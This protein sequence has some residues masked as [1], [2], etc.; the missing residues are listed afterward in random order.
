VVQ[1]WLLRGRHAPL[2]THDVLD[3]T[4]TLLGSRIRPR[5]ACRFARR[6]LESR[7][8][9]LVRADH[10]LELAALSLYQ[11]FD[12]R[13]LSFTDSLSFAVMRALGIPAAFAFDAHFEHAGFR[14]LRAESL[15]PG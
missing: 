13:R 2:T 11:R 15:P 10:E 7:I 3:E 4:V 5:H 6:L 12:D 14:T 8:M 1:R 9:T